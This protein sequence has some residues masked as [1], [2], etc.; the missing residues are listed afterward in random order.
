MKNLSFSI[1]NTRYYEYLRY[2]D[3][4]FIYINQINMINFS[5]FLQNKTNNIT[6][7]PF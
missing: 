2:K 6:A 4:N 3:N 7:L 5:F 1:S